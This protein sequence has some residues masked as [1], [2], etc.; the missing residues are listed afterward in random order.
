MKQLRI[1]LR[2]SATPQEIILWCRLKRKQLGYKFR[3]QHSFGRY[4]VDFYCK[5]KKLV[6]AS[7]RLVSLWLKKCKFIVNCKLKITKII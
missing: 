6:V 5:E 7:Q 1:K 3:R 4:I 2:N